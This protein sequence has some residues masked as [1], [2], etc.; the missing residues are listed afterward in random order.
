MNKINNIIKQWNNERP[1]LDVSSMGLIGRFKKIN[2]LLVKEMDKTFTDYD[3]NH[4]SF[5]VLATLRRSGKPYAL[6]PNELLATMMVTSGT[7][8]NRIDRLVKAGLVKRIANPNDGRGFII[9]LTD[10]GFSL[11]DKAVTAHVETQTKLTSGLSAK[12]QQ[13]LN[14]LLSKFLNSVE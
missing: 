5:D 9:S 1:D 12:E 11:I 8:T 2:S 4:A 13:Q 7:M 6:S 14:E 3:L 10:S